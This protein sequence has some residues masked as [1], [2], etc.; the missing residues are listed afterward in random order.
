M[1][2]VA[3]LLAAVAV[4]TVSSAYGG[5]ALA[6]RITDVDNGISQAVVDGTIFPSIERTL[7]YVDL[8]GTVNDKGTVDVY[9]V[10]TGNWVRAHC[11]FFFSFLGEDTDKCGVDAPMPE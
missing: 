1:R 9:R 5:S 4:V 7:P 10:K 3:T 2:I 8:D 11:R 6:W